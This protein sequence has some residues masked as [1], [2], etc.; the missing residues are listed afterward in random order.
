MGLSLG[1]IAATATIYINN[2]GSLKSLLAGRHRSTQ[3]ALIHSFI[4]PSSI[5]S[6]RPAYECKHSEA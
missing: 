3:E 6:T 5:C 4:I 1:H 2:P